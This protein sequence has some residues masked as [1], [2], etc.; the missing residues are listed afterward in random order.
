MPSIMA[1]SLC[2]RTHSDRTNFKM[3]NLMFDQHLEAVWLLAYFEEFVWSEKLKRNRKVKIEHIVGHF[4]L[5][6]KA[7]QVASTPSLGFMFQ[8]S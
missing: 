3:I 8:I 2:W 6:Y 4:K 7:N 1:T 5:R